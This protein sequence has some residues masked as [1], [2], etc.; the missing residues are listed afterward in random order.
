[1]I[2]NIFLKQKYRLIFQNISYIEFWKKKIVMYLFLETAQSAFFF[3]EKHIVEGL[4][5]NSKLT[6][7]LA[8]N[9]NWSNVPS[10]NGL[11]YLTYAT[12]ILLLI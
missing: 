4:P 3:G 2:N 10:I 6:T 12:T 7:F 1:M 8:G 5:L 11:H 9:K